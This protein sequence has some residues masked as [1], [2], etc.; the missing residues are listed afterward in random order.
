MELV[1]F[2]RSLQVQALIRGVATVSASESF[3]GELLPQCIAECG[4]LM[5][6]LSL[7]G[8]YHFGCD[9]TVQAHP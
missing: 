6:N 8:N 4:I 9:K 7:S 3:I 2:G 5:K 1:D